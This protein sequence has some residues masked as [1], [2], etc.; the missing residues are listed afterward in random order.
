MAQVGAFGGV[1]GPSITPP[2]VATGREEEAATPARERTALVFGGWSVYPTA[3]AGGFFDSNPEQ[4]GTGVKP[5]G[6][7]R[8]VPSFLAEQADGIH[9]TSIYGL[10]DGLVYTPENV[11]NAN[12]I[13]AKTGVA[14]TYQPLPDWIF[15]G[16]ADFTRQ[17]DLFA[18]L[19]V[20]HSLVPL[21]QTGVGLSPTTNPVSYNQITGAGSAQKNFSDGFVVGSGSIVDIMYS[22]APA[23]SPDGVFYTGTV[24]GG[25]WVI[26]DLYVYAEGSGDSRQY[27][28]S[29]LSSSGYRVVGGLGSDQ[30]GLFRGEAYAGFEAENYQAAAFGTVSSPAFGGRLHYFPV[31]ELTIDTA[32]SRTI[33]TSLLANTPT[34]IGTPTL[35]TTLLGQGNYKIAP[36]WEASG[37]AG[38]IHTDYIDNIRRDNAWTMGATV[39]YS[40]WQ[41]FGL[42]LD[43][44][45]INLRSNV[46]LQSF[47]RNVVTLGI[48]YKY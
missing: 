16:L 47:T 7:L 44:Q 37:R 8:L 31:P 13:T 19:G 28:T 26:P 30:I 42:T 22:N 23:P 11:A 14:E 4:L 39:T 40:V 27:A 43:Y 46:P 12:T 38:F 41:N 17:K 34:Q 5:G 36:E 18:T 10:V 35:V 1:G 29:G 48:T 32:F 15:N 2:P 9:K 20:A 33:G 24:R 3:F 45:Y 6:G 25:Y 21:N